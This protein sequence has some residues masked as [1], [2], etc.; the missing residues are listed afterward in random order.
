M[1]HIF[2]SYSHKDASLIEP[3]IGLLRA[4]KIDVF[5][6]VLSIAPGRKWRDEIEDAIHAAQLIVVFWCR[7]SAA[8]KE[9]CAEYEL[10][11]SAEK[12]VL[13][14]VLDGTP[15]PAVLSEYQ[16]IDF[17]KMSGKRH[18]IPR[19]LVVSALV[20]GAVALGLIVTEFLIE[21]P[22]LIT[23]SATPQRAVDDYLIGTALFA[24]V[25]AAAFWF[26]A[27][28]ARGQATRLIAGFILG[29]RKEPPHAGAGNESGS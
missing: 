22:Q 15:L 2:V 26:V 7:H 20:L 27:R 6:D 19:A 24:A 23:R 29:N 13:P 17:L 25:A 16:Y 1:S 8:S 5:Q 3:I 4:S 18:G 9:V 28:R 14:V 11:I 21:E 10:A 12:D